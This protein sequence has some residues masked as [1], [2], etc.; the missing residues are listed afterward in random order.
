MTRTSHSDTC[1]DSLLTIINQEPCESQ[2]P[3]SALELLQWL[4]TVDIL[5]F[6]I[7]H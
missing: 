3:A 2:S 7:S 4:V 5:L 1:T 6:P